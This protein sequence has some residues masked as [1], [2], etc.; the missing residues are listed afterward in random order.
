MPPLGSSLP[1]IMSSSKRVPFQPPGAE[2]RRVPVFRL[3]LGL[4][5]TFYVSLLAWEVQSGLMHICQI[6]P[7]LAC[8]EPEAKPQAGAAGAYGK[9][10]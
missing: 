10:W 2:R 7:F 8:E 1:I 4:I 3:V 9:A 6:L 5:L